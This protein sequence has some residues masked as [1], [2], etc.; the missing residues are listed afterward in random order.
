MAFANYLQ[1]SNSLALLELNGG[2][3]KAT[4]Q[5]FYGAPPWGLML[6]SVL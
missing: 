3:R 4:V 1:Y 6:I 5:E 2:E